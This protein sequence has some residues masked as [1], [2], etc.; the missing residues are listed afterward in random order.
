MRDIPSVRLFAVWESKRENKQII[1]IFTNLY[2][3]HG[4]LNDL[5]KFNINTK[6]TDTIRV[7]G[8]V[9]DLKKLNQ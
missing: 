6:L 9:L 7:P 8:V 1:T 4:V 2:M 5:K 3:S